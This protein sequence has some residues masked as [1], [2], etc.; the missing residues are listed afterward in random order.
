MVSDAQ[1]IGGAQALNS[2]HHNEVPDHMAAKSNSTAHEK[3]DGPEESLAYRHRGLAAALG[4]SP[5][6]LSRKESAGLIP[7]PINLGG[8][9]MWVR[10]EITE[11]IRAGC[12]PRSKWEEVRRKYSR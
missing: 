1:S 8:T 2:S 9:K 5:R 6:T 12:P 7:K 3:V 10:A 4:M 11:W